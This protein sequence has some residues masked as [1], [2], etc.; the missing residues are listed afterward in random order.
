MSPLQFGRIEDDLRAHLSTREV[1]A[2]DCCAGADSAYRLGVRVVN[3]SDDPVF[4]LEVPIACPH[5]PPELL[6]PC[7]TGQTLPRTTRALRLAGTF[8]DN[9]AA[10]AADVSD[11]V[12]RAA[13]APDGGVLG[14]LR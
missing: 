12:R 5:V 3:D 1:F 2:Q 6:R 10:S 9:F 7:D 13:R 14:R 4:A 8:R 11:D